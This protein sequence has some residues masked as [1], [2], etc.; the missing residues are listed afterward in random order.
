MMNA[1][2]HG[3]TY[4]Y[5]QCHRNELEDRG[6]YFEEDKV[7]QEAAGLPDA[8]TNAKEIYRLHTGI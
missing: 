7:L 3:T 1:R 5:S 8:T 6:K 4:T 2:H